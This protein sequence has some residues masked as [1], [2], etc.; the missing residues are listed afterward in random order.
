MP[1]SANDQK[2]IQD[3]LNTD[4]I[5]KKIVL[6]DSVESTNDLAKTLGLEGSQEGT[7]VLAYSQTRGKGRQGRNW[8]SEP[9]TGLYFS[10]LLHP[11]TSPELI[12]QV[13]LVAGVALVQ[14]INQFSQVRAVLKWP[15]DVLINHKKVAGIL[16][17]FYQGGDHNGIVVGIGVNVN[18]SR[19][20]VELQHIAT[21]LAMEN[22]GSLEKLPLI[23]AI[24]NQLEKKYWTFMDGD[25]ASIILEWNQNSDLFGKH[26]TLTRGDE[27]FHG[28]A[29]KLNEEGQLIMELETGQEMAFD[30]GEITSME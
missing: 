27:T 7:V 22:S 23:A 1:Y 16:T 8:H 20:P 2:W 14:A 19:F 13:T 3:Q 21:S 5:G 10:V 26:L 4:L 6:H 11:T 9:H 29:M 18:Q 25:F 12:H 17:E 15:N 30:S 24:I 28:T